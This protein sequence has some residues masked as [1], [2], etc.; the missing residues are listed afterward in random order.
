MNC[1]SPTGIIVAHFQIGLNSRYIISY[2]DGK[3]VNHVQL[4]CFAA[5]FL[6]V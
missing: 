5:S 3:Q 6:G 1:S 4:K 2:D